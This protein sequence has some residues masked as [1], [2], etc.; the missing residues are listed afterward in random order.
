MVPA[1][2]LRPALLYRVEQG[3]PKIQVYPT[4]GTMTLF[5]NR[6]FVDV[7]CENEVILD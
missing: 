1:S 5:S 6:V 7:S 3:L 2:T 4:P